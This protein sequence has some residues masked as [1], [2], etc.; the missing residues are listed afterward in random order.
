MEEAGDAVVR[1]ALDGASRQR[2]TARCTAGKNERKRLGSRRDWRHR[3]ELA[4]AA[5]ERGGQ[6]RATRLG[7]KHREPHGGIRIGLDVACPAEQA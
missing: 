5:A 3:V 4:C 2:E 7:E 6:L 1:I